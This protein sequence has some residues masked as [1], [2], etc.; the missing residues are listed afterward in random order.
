MSPSGENNQ[1]LLAAVQGKQAT[2]CVDYLIPFS[3]S[4]AKNEALCGAALQG[5]VAL[6]RRLIEAGADVHTLNDH[7]L[8]VACVH[9]RRAVVELL[10]RE[11]ADPTVFTPEDIAAFPRATRRLV[12]SVSRCIVV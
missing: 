4:E 3:D 11:G 12:Q 2:L 1:A 5:E 7:P 9:G 6:V 10:L 8:Y